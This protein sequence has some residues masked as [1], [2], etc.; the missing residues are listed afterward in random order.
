MHTKRLGNSDLYIT[1][2]GFVWTTFMICSLPLFVVALRKTAL[3]ATASRAAVLAGIAVCWFG[4]Q[5][6]QLHDLWPLVAHA[7]GVLGLIGI[8]L[9]LMTLDS[10]QMLGR[11][12]PALRATSSAS[13]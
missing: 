4:M 6:V 7:V 9:A 1:P 10:R 5:I 8:T 2:F 13:G 12:T 11:S 3:L